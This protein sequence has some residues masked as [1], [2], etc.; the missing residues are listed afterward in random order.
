MSLTREDV[1]HVASLARL[2]LSD[3]E[4]DTLQDQLSSI[5][6]HIEVLNQLDT[7]AIPP[8][9]QVIQLE[10]VLRPDEVRPSLP[11]TTVVAMAPETRDGFI[12]VA[13]VMGGAEDEGTT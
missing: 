9:A 10:N 3:D 11:Q 6:G 7:E 2:G 4:L 8:T 5:L 12:A 13:A 1:E